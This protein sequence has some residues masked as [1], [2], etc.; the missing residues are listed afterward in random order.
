MSAQ[1]LGGNVE[2]VKR[3]DNDWGWRRRAANGQ[4]IATSGEG[5]R[6]KADALDMVARQY[7]DI[8][9]LVIE[10]EAKEPVVSEPVPPPE[11]DAA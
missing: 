8:P 3:T 7:P 9:I 2:L 6:N 10:V 11:D 5:Y 4:V 1:P